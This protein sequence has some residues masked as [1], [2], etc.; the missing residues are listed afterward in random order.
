MAPIGTAMCGHCFHCDCFWRWEQAKS[1]QNWQGG[2]HN[3][4]CPCPVCNHPVLEFVRLYIAGDATSETAKLRKEIKRVTK[5]LEKE[6]LRLQHA[7]KKLQESSAIAIPKT[8]ERAISAPRPRQGNSRPSSSILRGCGSADDDDILD[9]LTTVI[10]LLSSSESPPPEIAARS[11]TITTS[12]RHRLDP[13]RSISPSP[14]RLESRRETFRASTVS[15]R[16]GV[17]PSVPQIMVSPPPPASHNRNIG[18]SPRRSAPDGGIS[19]STSNIAIVANT[20][21]ARQDAPSTGCYNARRSN[22]PRLDPPSRYPTMLN[23][24]P[25]SIVVDDATPDDVSSLPS[26]SSLLWWAGQDPP[27]CRAPQHPNGGQTRLIHIPTGTS[28]RGGCGM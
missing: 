14:R 18:R 27:S 19:P 5:K 12:R 6:R 21:S 7:E 13:F 11:P 10:Q 20:S 17:Q 3:A 25:P 2:R 28:R 8:S 9:I 16:N 26:L 22:A 23:A 4:H 15:G 1:A 24:G